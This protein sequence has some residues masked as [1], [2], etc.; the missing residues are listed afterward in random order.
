M[1]KQIKEKVVAVATSEETKFVVKNVAI[2]VTSYILTYVIVA[3]VLIGTNALIG[4]VLGS[5]EVDEA[6]ALPASTEIAEE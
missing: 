5:P 4:A 6:E 1:F 3:G 2:G